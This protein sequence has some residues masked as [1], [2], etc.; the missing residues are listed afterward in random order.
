M[1][2]IVE[3]NG[4]KELV[5]TWL[6]A[7]PQSRCVV[8]PTIPHATRFHGK[9]VAITSLNPNPAR[10]GRQLK[11]L[12]SWLDIGL[13]VVVVNTAAE[14]SNL[15]SQISG[16]MWQPSEELTTD[17]DRQTIRVS[18]LVNIGISIGLPFMLL[19]SDIE[20]Q[21]RHEHITQA[22]FNLGKL[23]IGVR[24]NYS[25]KL[26]AATSEPW[27]LDCFLMTPEMAKTLPQMP[28]GLGKPVWDYWLPLHFRELYYSFNWI[29]EP[30]FYHESHPIA[31]SQSEWLF[32]AETLRQQYGVSLFH[33]SAAFRESL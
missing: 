11:C 28:F 5:P 23:T 26:Q 32:G 17:Y 29:V 2:T 6:P 8:T 22:L 4:R 30:F 12:Q 9:C 20:I 3:R 18:A 33:D 14:I 19:N 7:I 16:V 24:W 31:W 21:G 1:R 25:G 13:P 27:G 15:K 10:L